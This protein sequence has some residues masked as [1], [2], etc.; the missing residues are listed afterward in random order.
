MNK[1]SEQDLYNLALSFYGF[2]VLNNERTNE[3]YHISSLR[4]AQ[5]FSKLFEEGDKTS[6]EQILGVEIVSKIDLLSRTFICLAF[7][8][9]S[10]D[11]ASEY[12]EISDR[13]FQGIL[14]EFERKTVPNSEQYSFRMYYYLFEYL[15][16]DQNLSLLSAVESKQY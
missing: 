3:K 14:D 5:F 11:L 9:L 12:T 6:K 2:T 16:Q 4:L 15:K 13:I 10:D 8:S 1:L 7:S